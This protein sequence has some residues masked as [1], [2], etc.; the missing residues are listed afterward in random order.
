MKEQIHWKTKKFRY[1]KVMEYQNKISKE[2]MNKKIGKDIEVLIENMSFDG[3]YYIGR[4]HQDVP[5]IDG[6]VYIKNDENKKLL[7]KII[8][9]EVIDC[10]DYDLVAKIK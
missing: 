6:L 9:C 1:N 10:T 2:I 4:T 5:D 3:K 8:K 7:D